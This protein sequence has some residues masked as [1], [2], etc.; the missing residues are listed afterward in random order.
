MHP[1]LVKAGKVAA[2][3]NI[4]DQKR[5][6]VLGCIG[7]R[8][9]GVSVAAK[10]GSVITSS[11]NEYRVIS[12][13]HAEMRCIKKMGR[14]GILYVA[15]ILKRDGSYA[16]SRPCGQCRMRIKMAGIERVFYTIDDYYYGLY[17]VESDTDRIYEA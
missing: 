7:I 3:S 2:S 8:E 1:L 15:R 6:F 10:N 13:A 16:M 4:N 12:D 11:Y 17:L 14:G 9:D 5:N